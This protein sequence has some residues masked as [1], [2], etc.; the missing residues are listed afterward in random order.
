M[1]AVA[2]LRPDRFE[3]G[4]LVG[5][6]VALAAAL[7]FGAH[8]LFGPRRTPAGQPPLARITTATFPDLRRAFNAAADRPRVL[9]LLSPT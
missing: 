3:R 4:T 2:G 1:A 9:V 6:C 5:S 7:L 8:D